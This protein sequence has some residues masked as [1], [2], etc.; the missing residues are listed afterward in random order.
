MIEEKKNQKR[1]NKNEMQYNENI[2]DQVPMRS[3]LGKSEDDK[4]EDAEKEGE[5]INS[6]LYD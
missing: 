6:D 5:I 4:A 3:N 2:P 1:E